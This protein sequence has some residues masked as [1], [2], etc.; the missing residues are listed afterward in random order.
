M[1]VSVYDYGKRGKCVYM[2]RYTEGGSRE[3]KTQME[4][5]DQHK[6][7]VMRTSIGT[8]TEVSIK[9]SE[10]EERKQKGGQEYRTKHKTRSARNTGRK[11]GR[12]ESIHTRH[13]LIETGKQT[14]KVREG[15]RG[16]Y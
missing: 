12:E 7:R 2:F 16:Y 4:K 5:K 1:A 8:V 14:K 11:T 13:R 15:D 10:K 9:L 3:R 6:V